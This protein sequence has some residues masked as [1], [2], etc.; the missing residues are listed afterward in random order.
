MIGNIV[1]FAARIF[2][3]RAA[4]KFISRLTGNRREQDMR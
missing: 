4:Y 1:R 2:L 3:L